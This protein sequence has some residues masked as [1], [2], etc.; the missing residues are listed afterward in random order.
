M[1]AVRTRRRAF[2]LSLS[3][4]LPMKRTEKESYVVNRKNSF[5]LSLITRSIL[6][7][8]RLISLSHSLN[9]Y[10]KPSSQ[11]QHHVYHAPTFDVVILRGFLVVHLLSTENQPLLHRRDAFLLFHSLFDS[12]DGIGDFDVEFDLFASQGFHFDHHLVVVV[13]SSPPQKKILRARVCV[14]VF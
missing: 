5:S 6:L 12:N 10:L 11:G 9:V 2:L 3:V 7:F 1:C 13:L 14:S 8:L 4:S